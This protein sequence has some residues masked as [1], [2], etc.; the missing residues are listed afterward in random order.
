MYVYHSLP[1]SL[2]HLLLPQ[3]H[4][5]SVRSMQWSHNSLWMATTD[6]R[7]MVK[8]WQS[9]MNNVHTF[10]AHN[11][12]IRGCRWDP[13]N[14]APG[15]LSSRVHIHI[16]VC[17]LRDKYTLVHEVKSE[18]TCNISSIFRV[19]VNI[20]GWYNIRRVKSTCITLIFI[21]G[22]GYCTRQYPQEGWD[23]FIK[24]CGN[25]TKVPFTSWG[26]H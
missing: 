13:R 18:S 23:L 22:H 2:P 19:C 26:K 3:A 21:C 9:N 4:D 17:H 8:Y 14:G 20:C 5:S 15:M 10:Q 24:I 12:P 7:G 16:H 25:K 1:P 11:E 6:D